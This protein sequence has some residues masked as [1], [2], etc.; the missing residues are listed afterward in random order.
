M[1][2][3]E[4]KQAIDAGER[5]L[6]SLNAARE[7]LSSA[8]GWGVV[9]MLGGGLLST[10]LKRNRMHE[11]NAAMERAKCDLEQFRDELEDVN[12]QL[13]TG[14]FVGFADY[15]FDGLFAD[16]AVG[17]RISEAQSSVMSVRHKIEQ[18]MHKLTSMEQA[19]DK[20][21]A[22]LKAKIEELVIHA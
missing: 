20:Q 12:I 9:D 16:W 2:E 11:A 6:Q 5:A 8:K 21:V 7:A 17:D 10:I 19:A 22:A 1:N 3:L 18:A 13:A 15:F 14:D 4:R